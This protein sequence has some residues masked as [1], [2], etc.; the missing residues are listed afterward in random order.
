MAR[1]FRFASES[2]SE[3]HPD[4]VADQ[5]SDGILDL[6]LTQDPAARVAYETLVSTGL[7]V[8]SGEITTARAHETIAKRWEVIRRIGYDNS[9]IGFRPGPARSSAAINQQSAD[10]ARGVNNANELTAS[11]RARATRT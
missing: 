11:T 7:V 6:I 2:V 4:K 8:I 10:I 3:G 1:E 9:D 5:V